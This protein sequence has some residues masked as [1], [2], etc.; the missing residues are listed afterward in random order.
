V[1]G[2]STARVE[3]VRPNHP[4]SLETSAEQTPISVSRG[5]RRPAGEGRPGRRGRATVLALR[6][7]RLGRAC[8]VCMTVMPARCM[9]A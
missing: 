4:A 7:A 8:E 9:L 1:P 6:S 5:P 2:R 3:T